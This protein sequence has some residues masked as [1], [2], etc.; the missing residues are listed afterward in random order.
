MET[1]KSMN[2]KLIEKK[3][4]RAVKTLKGMAV[5][6]FSPYHR[7]IPDRIVLMPGGKTYF[8]ELKTTGKKPTSLQI[9][10]MNDLK[11]LGFDVR[12]VDKQESLDKFLEDIK[13]G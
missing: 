6:F 13:H 5:K 2:E 11:K 8:V 7:G 4:C 9:K 3:L 10:A 12:V 1:I